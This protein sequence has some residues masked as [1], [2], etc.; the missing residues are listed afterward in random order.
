MAD[1]KQEQ[2]GKP[3]GKPPEQNRPNLGPK[4]VRRH[5][6]KMVTPAGGKGYLTK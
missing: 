1:Q 5:P 3:E 4:T 2:G 6:D